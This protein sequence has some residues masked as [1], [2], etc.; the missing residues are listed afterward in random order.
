MYERA[1]ARDRWYR[2]VGRIVF[3]WNN[4]G[5]CEVWMDGVKVVN[6]PTTNIGYNDLI[7]PYWKFGVYRAAVADTLVVEYAN[8]EI[9]A[10]SLLSR[11]TSPLALA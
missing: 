2:F 11:V 4:N 5:A 7:G 8:M 10:T 6:L 3:G 1:I 9:G